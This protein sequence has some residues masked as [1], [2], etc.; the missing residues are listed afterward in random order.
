MR[1]FLFAIGLWFVTACAA[2]ITIMSYN[3][4]NLFHPASDSIN[5]DSEFTPSGS[6]R[7]TYTRYYRKLEQIARVIAN[8][9][10]DDYPAIVALNEVEDRHCLQDLCRKMPH[11][12]YQIIHFDSQDH[13]GIDVALL[14]D[15][16]RFHRLIAQTISPITST[17]DLLYA[18]LMTPANDTL[19]LIACHLPSQLSGTISRLRRDTLKAAIHHLTDSVLLHSPNAQIIVCGDMNTAPADDLQPLTNL[20]VNITSG[21]HKYRGLWTCLDQFYVS[22]ALISRASAS[23]F[24]AR[25]LQEEDMKFLGT[26]PVRTF[27]GFRYNRQGFS[28]H[29]PILLRLSMECYG[30]K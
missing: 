23:V 29:L 5:T 6:H 7:W 19:H 24:N 8:S 16:T 25:W 27:I 14:Y 4:E 15:S 26:R 2:Q 30:E 17:R 20:M 3:V 1:Y 11:Y 28:D 18:K 22:P 12:P 13:R 10:A 9:V 21:S